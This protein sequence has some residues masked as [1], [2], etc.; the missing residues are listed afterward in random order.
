[1]D[2]SSET[3]PVPTPV[4]VK[5]VVRRKV[6]TP[7]PTPA[8]VSTSLETSGD[9]PSVPTSISSSV[10]EKKPRA[11]KAK[12][13]TTTTK[14]SEIQPQDVEVASLENPRTQSQ[15]ISE[16]HELYEDEPVVPSVKKI[17]R[18]K[19]TTSTSKSK[20]NSKD[21]GSK[22]VGR[23]TPK[24]M[25]SVKTVYQMTVQED[26]T[27]YL[28]GIL[29][30]AS[31]HV[32]EGNLHI[33]PEGLYFQG[34]DGSHVSVLEFNLHRSWFSEFEAEPHTRVIGIPFKI[35]SSVLSCYSKAECISLYGG[36]ATCEE[37]LSV[38]IREK[39]NIH[40]FEVPL[41]SV[42]VDLLEIPEQ[43][44]TLR[45][46][47]PIEN[48]K[49]SCDRLEKLEIEAPELIYEIIPGEDGESDEAVL[50]MKGSSS[51]GLK[52]NIAMTSLTP[53][54]EEYRS[55]DEPLKTCIA[56]RFI[57][58]YLNQSS[59]FKSG[60]IEI[61]E[62]IPVVLTS[63]LNDI[64]EISVNGESQIVYSGAGEPFPGDS[65]VSRKSMVRIFVA[66]RTD[67]ES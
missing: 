2:V 54:M 56:L 24:K 38:S 40:H 14:S 1:M 25:I 31:E 29:K 34:M 51:N 63:E 17:S 4:P 16:L 27:K 3:T 12:S 15:S 66:P 44:H 6:S 43:H 39:D 60:T 45:L 57:K 47:I 26:K 53:D 22:S 35:L 50:S 48:I 11:T 36:E 32:G 19:K 13:K 67:D 61:T 49:S 52:V 65:E 30:M 42:D 23:R 62:G 37:K 5:K 8:L 59:I 20:S 55:L 41:L 58:S 46:T 18:T 28:M 10:P 64:P 9:V 7:A 33:R 21:A